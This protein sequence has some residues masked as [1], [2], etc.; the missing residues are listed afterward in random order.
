MS[1]TT[2]APAGLRIEV[3]R[4]GSKTLFLGEDC[5]G[6]T[7][8]GRTTGTRTAF[9]VRDGYLK[10]DFPTDEAATDALLTAFAK[11]APHEAGE[12]HRET[13]RGIEFVIIFQPG[14]GGIDGQGRG[15][16]SAD[17]FSIVYDGRG[18]TCPTGDVKTVAKKARGWV[19]QKHTDEA[20]LP[21]LVGLVDARKS[22]EGMPGWDNGAAPMVGDTAYVYAMG[23]YRR[24]VVTK[25]TKTSATVSY[26]TASSQGRVFHKADKFDELAA[27]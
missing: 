6:R 14:T 21:K 1:Q 13:Y 18:V 10:N 24:G 9:S 4:Y 17:R 16:V 11:P 20:L 8:R 5:I 15:S 27:G 12:V 22:A 25:V 26:T 3:D 7:T 19:D 2:T 23:R